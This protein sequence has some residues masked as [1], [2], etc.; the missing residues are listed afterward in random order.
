MAGLRSFGKSFVT[1]GYYVYDAAKLAVSGTFGVL[2]EFGDE[3]R[4]LIL[5]SST[6]D[7]A[8]NP[9]DEMTIIYNK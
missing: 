9:G 3:V 6:Q 8:L 2:Y 1:V 4:Y 7:S 5:P